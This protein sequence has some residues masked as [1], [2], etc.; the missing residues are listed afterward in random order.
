MNASNNAVEEWK[1][2][3][4]LWH[5]AH[6]EAR[7]AHDELSRL[8]VSAHDGGPAPT[9][10]QIYLAAELERRADVLRLELDGFVLGYMS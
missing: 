5:A 6:Q 9:V 7:K 10:D 2:L 8:A 4:R 1:R 3:H